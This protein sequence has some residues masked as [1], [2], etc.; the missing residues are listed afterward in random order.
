[1]LGTR[2]QSLPPDPA[3][4]REVRDW[5]QACAKQLG[6][7]GRRPRSRARRHAQ[8]SPP[9]LQAEKPRAKGLGFPPQGKTDGVYFMMKTWVIAMSQ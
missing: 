6:R 8:L 9:R 4:G 7:C 2:C 3:V 5:R 1:M